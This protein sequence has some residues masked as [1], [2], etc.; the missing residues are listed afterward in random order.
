[1]YIIVSAKQ[2]VRSRTFAPVCFIERAMNTWAGFLGL[3]KYGEHGGLR[4]YS[5]KLISFWRYVQ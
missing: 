3:I 2:S 5:V 1:M 4:D